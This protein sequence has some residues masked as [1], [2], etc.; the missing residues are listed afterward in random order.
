LILEDLSGDTAAT[1]QYET[2]SFSKHTSNKFST[3]IGWLDL[4]LCFI[5]HITVGDFGVIS[6]K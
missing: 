4:L 1:S 6:E 5:T 2:T 3:F